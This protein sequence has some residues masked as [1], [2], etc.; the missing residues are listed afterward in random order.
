[1]LS[2]YRYSSESAKQT[3]QKP[4]ICLAIFVVFFGAI[5]SAKAN[6]SET[7][8]FQ[9]VE[10]DIRVTGQISPRVPGGEIV[11]QKIDVTGKQRYDEWLNSTQTRSIRQYKAISSAISID[12]YRVR[13]RFRK[14]STLVVSDL[15][16]DKLHLY[17]PAGPMTS[18][19][20]ELIDLQGSLLVLYQMLP[21]AELKQGLIFDARYAMLAKLLSLG[22]VS[23]GKVSGNVSSLTDSIASLNWT[24]SVTGATD[25]VATDLDL[26]IASQFDQRRH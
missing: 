21:D 22:E 17:S 13:P 18:E 8:H 16:D 14:Q 9:Q 1:M 25:G 19:E 15:T 12:D 5:S 24:G 2:I 6:Q 4:V 10:V 3:L 11:N 7:G 23:G 20:L 26:A